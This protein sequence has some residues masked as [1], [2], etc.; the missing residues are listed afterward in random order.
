MHRTFAAPRC[1][2]IRI[3][4]GRWLS[5][6]ICRT[7]RQD[8]DALAAVKR[9]LCCTGQAAQMVR[10]STLSATC[11]RHPQVFDVPSR[12]CSRCAEPGDAYVEGLTA[13]TRA[14]VKERSVTCAPPLLATGAPFMMPQETERGRQPDKGKR[15]SSRDRV[16]YDFRA[17]LI[18][19]QKTSVE[20][21]KLSQRAALAPA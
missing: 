7:D 1:R 4:A 8:T 3:R 5:G 17:H 20:L 15:L 14:C 18:A 13:T 11:Q 2:R 16:R 21:L 12:A 9:S 10:R 6:K 19:G